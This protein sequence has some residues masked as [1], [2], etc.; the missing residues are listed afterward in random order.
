MSDIDSFL[1]DV[2]PENLANDPVLRKA[3]I[4]ALL[5]SDFYLPVEESETEQAERGGVSLQAVKIHDIAH[6]LMFSNEVRLKEFCPTGTRFARV[7]GNALFPSLEGQF[8]ILNP[9]P[10]G[11]ILT[12]DDIAEILGKPAKGS[13]S[14]ASGSESE[15]GPSCGSTGHV[16]GPDC[17]H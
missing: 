6:V 13:Q 7:V 11:L 15:G 10:S 4:V 3:F 9:G 12:P 8:G 16:H 2:P 14:P 17:Q 1:K 5:A